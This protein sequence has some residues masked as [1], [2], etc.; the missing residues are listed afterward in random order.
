MGD[1]MFV[2]VLF[3][4]TILLLLLLNLLV[5]HC[6]KSGEWSILSIYLIPTLC[7]GKLPQEIKYADSRIYNNVITNDDGDKKEDDTYSHPF[8]LL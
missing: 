6:Y 8:R 5:I 1:F 4:T 7:D 3:T 2:S